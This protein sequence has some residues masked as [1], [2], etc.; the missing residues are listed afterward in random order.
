MD[1]AKLFRELHYSEQP[2]I[3]ANAC[4]PG[5]AKELAAM[6]FKAIVT[7]SAAVAEAQGCYVHCMQI[8]N[9]KP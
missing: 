5:S 2:L 8:P 4:E 6:G 1:H 3:V 9:F 7:S